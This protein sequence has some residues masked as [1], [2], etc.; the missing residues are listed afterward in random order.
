[1]LAGEDKRRPDAVRDKR[2]RDRSH[3]DCF[4]PGADDQPDIGVTQ[5][6]P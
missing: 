5:Y 1:M 6:S 4:R 3:F 2:K